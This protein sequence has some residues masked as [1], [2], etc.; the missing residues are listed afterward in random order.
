MSFKASLPPGARLLRPL[1]GSQQPHATSPFS[2]R[3]GVGV[4]AA[5]PGRAGLCQEAPPPLNPSQPGQERQPRSLG[6]GKHNGGFGKRSE[7]AGTKANMDKGDLGTRHLLVT[8]SS[9]V[10]CSVSSLHLYFSLSY[11]PG[12]P[13][14]G[15]RSSPGS[16]SRCPRD[17]APRKRNFLCKDLAVPA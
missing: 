17:K 13:E 3:R 16:V 4:P 11:E 2:L 7:S 8:P 1:P 12:I 6:G 5:G 14:A 15:A 9:R 10:F